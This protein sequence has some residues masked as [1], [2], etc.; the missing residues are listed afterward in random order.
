VLK[1]GLPFDPNYKSTPAQPAKP[2]Q[3]LQPA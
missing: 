1:T 3:L 2:V